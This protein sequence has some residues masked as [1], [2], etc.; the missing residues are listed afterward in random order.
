ML[1]TRFLILESWSLF[2]L[3]SKINEFLSRHDHEVIKF[4]ELNFAFDHPREGPIKSLHHIVK[5]FT[6]LD[7]VLRHL[8]HV[9]KFFLD[10]GTGVTVLDKLEWASLSD[11]GP[12]EI[13]VK[14]FLAVR[15]IDVFIGF[16]T[17]DRKIGCEVLGSFSINKLR[18]QILGEENP[19][20][21]IPRLAFLFAKEILKGG[22]VVALMLFV[23][24]TIRPEFESIHYGIDHRRMDYNAGHSVSAS[25]EDE[26]L[27]SKK[28]ESLS[29]N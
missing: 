2:V 26:W 13:G 24:M 5:D 27:L 16:S 18:S 17:L 8:H 22:M 1:K 28:Q 19:A 11:G 15:I 9:V 21:A 6:N 25:P 12:E 14:L 7:G 23:M 29:P 20:G 3:A 4:I 10:V